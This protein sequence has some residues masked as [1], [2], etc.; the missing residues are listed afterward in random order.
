[1]VLAL[2]SGLS[3]G[4]ADTI[5]PFSALA[6]AC[7]LVVT[8]LGYRIFQVTDETAR[9]L[10]EKKLALTFLHAA[11]ELSE[12]SPEVTSVLER[13]FD[14]FLQHYETPHVPLSAS[15]LVAIKPA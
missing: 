7:S 15:D 3:A 8:V 2:V 13:S 1:M 6:V 11:V 4:V 10:K 14:M 5:L 12:G 9:R